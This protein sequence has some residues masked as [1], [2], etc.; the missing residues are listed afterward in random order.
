MDKAYEKQHD[1]KW[2]KY[3]DDERLAVPEVAHAR[4]KAP[5]AKTFALLMP[6]PNVTGVL[7][8]GHALML[9][10]E[11]TLTRWNRMSGIEAL[12]LPGTDHA[13][14]AVQMQVVK[15]LA[16]KGIDHRSLGREGFLKE[17]WNWINE[18]RPRIYGQVRSM[19]T[20]CDWERVKFTMDAELNK[21]VTHAFVELHKRGLIY[22]AE[23]LVN[24]SPK[25]QTVLSDLEVIFKEQKGHIWHLKYPLAGDSTKHIVVATTR[26]ETMLGDVAVAV[27]PSDERYK[28]L[29]GKKILLPIVGREIPII[30][31][32]FVDAAFGTG[33]VK[34]TPAHDFNDFEV[35]ERHGFARLNIFTPEA[36]LVPGLPGKAAA[37]A[38]LDRFVARDKVVEEFKALGLLD[39]IEDHVNRVGTSE[40]WGEIVEPYLS[41]QWFLKMDGMAA[42]AAEAV[43]A[44]RIEIVPHEFH[45]QFM[46]WMENIH[47]WCISRQLWWGQQ[48]PAYHCRKTGEVVVSE[49]PPPSSPKHDWVQ[50]PDVLDTWFSSGLWPLTTLGWPDVKA[51]DLRKFYPTSVLE[52][53]FDIL[54]FW[55]ARMVMM[56]MEFVDEVPFKKVYMHPMVRDENGQKMSKSK[57]NVIDPLEIV[58]E[59]G[60]DTLRLTLNGLCVQGRDLRL[61]TE[62]L[63]FYRAFIN[64][65]WNATRFALMKSE[66]ST[67]R[68]WMKRPLK[69]SHLHDRWIL[70]RLD[71]ASRDL[72][73]AWG[74]FRMQEA[75]DTLYHFIWSDF[76]D[77]YLE[78]AKATRE[79]SDNIVKHVLGEILKMMHP[80]CP[81]ATEELWHGMPGVKIEE[82]LLVQSFPQG[83]GFP[84]TEALAEFKF[85]QD[86]VGQIR[87]LKAESK[88]A[89]SKAIRIWIKD[90]GPLSQKVVESSRATLISMARLSD[91]SWGD[92]PAG[93]ASTR[94][95]VSAVEAGKTVEI[96][97]PMTELKDL[98][99][100]VDRLRKELSSLE[101]LAS[102]QEGKLANKNFVDRAPPEVIDKEK[103][104]L[105]EYR[106]KVVKL[107]STLKQL[108][109]Q[110]KG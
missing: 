77:W 20:N 23:K 93:A 2:Q 33:A 31:D 55:V 72:N 67:D 7:H 95:P 1:K 29:V 4:H 74:E 110:V 46:R 35:G 3:W 106:D 11:D 45:N 8:Q 101:K 68:T 75:V 89:P 108:E 104:K 61:S 38:G 81:H 87:T 105:E 44:K 59:F 102:S 80:L 91:L 6:P 28:H 99:D 60:A 9:A 90:A 88:V 54:F 107:Q 69:V 10:L 14:I 37:W 21:G 98:A 86:V 24:W 18:Y 96:V 19:G 66:G 92:A 27:S 30:A 49:T 50:D 56:C 85:F 63:D 22:R 78:C 17:C 79:D 26:P 57:G 71:E 12:Y 13:S 82:S 52:T 41:H 16:S 51:E 97:V 48:I 36:H 65:I 40:R 83:E 32:A 94:L 25:G 47:D 76:C 43:R 62:R 64:K 70:A 100:E 15:H 53:G 39:R 58:E 5:L 73:K 103:I 34:I 109:A 42:R 84:D